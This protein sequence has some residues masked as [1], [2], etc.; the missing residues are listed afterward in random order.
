[1]EQIVIDLRRARDDPPAHDPQF[2]AE[3]R[4]FADALRSAGLG[5]SRQGATGYSQPQ[6][7]VSL[8]P[9]MGAI[10]ASILTTWIQNQS[11]RSVRAT[12]GDRAFELQSA[13]DLARLVENINQI[14]GGAETPKGEG[15]A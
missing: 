1:M 10:F 4:A 9:E 6:F 12:L 13:E 2:Q 14:R 3:L 5:Y 8:P 15:G 11:G 7:L